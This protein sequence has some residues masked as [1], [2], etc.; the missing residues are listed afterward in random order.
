M[1]FLQTRNWREARK[2]QGGTDAPNDFASIIYNGRRGTHDVSSGGELTI[3]QANQTKEENQNYGR[4]ITKIQPEEGNTE[5]VP[6]R[7]RCT[8]EK[9]G[10][11]R[12]AGCK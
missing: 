10:R 2:P 1:P 6:G 3:P 11:G 9:A 12:Q 7:Q 8:K 4:P 5:T